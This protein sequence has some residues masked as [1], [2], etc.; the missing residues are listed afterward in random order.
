MKVLCIDLKSFYASVE[1]VLR[2]LDPFMTDLVV[3]DES[4]GGGSV[5]L[6]VT[7]HLKQKGVP[8]RCRLYE[9]PKDM[10]IIIAKPRM[11]KYIDFASMIYKVYLKYV[12]E[13]DIHVYSID[14]AFLDVTNYMSYYKM[15]VEELAKKILQD[16]Y[17]TTKV[18]GSAGIGDN[19]FLAKVAL[20]CLAKKSPE[21]VFY[22]DQERFKKYI[23]DITPLTA[24]WGIG[25]GVAKRLA[26]R[27]IVSMRDIANTDVCELEREFGVI[28]RELHEHAHGVDPSIVSEIRNYKPSAKTFGASQILFRDY[29]FR[30]IPVILSEMIDDIVCK[31]VER[32]L[33]TQLIELG[34]GYSKETGGGFY[35]Q[36]TLSKPIFSKKELYQEF[37]KIYQENISFSPIRKV[38]VRVGK[39]SK[40]HFIQ[41]NLFEVSKD[42]SK[43][44]HLYQA[45]NYV[46]QRFGSNAIHL[47]ISYTDAGTKVLRNSLIGGH[48]AN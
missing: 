17:E 2:G 38:M 28:G 15:T 30:E 40:E 26:K 25:S 3:A 44:K 4:R 9:L 42:Y 41:E 37:M 6:A 35:K 7:P 8:S 20:D 1:C 29:H 45:I 43:D 31:L 14:E 36:R 12:S 11:Q 23:W 24:I 5:I 27:N 19:M 33:T 16:I 32:D 47:A 34:I 39:L 13:E 21:G 10:D 46:K 18:T 22:L 48:N